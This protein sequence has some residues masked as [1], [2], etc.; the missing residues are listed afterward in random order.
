MIIKWFGIFSNML[1]VLYNKT[2]WQFLY[3]L[4]VYKGTNTS[5]AQMQTFIIMTKASSNDV[6]KFSTTQLWM[7][8][9]Q[10]RNAMKEL[11]VWKTVG[12]IEF[13][14]LHIFRNC[15]TSTVFRWEKQ[16][17]NV[18]N[19]SAT[20]IL[21][22]SVLQNINFLIFINYRYYN[23]CLFWKTE[24]CG[25]QCLEHVFFFIMLQL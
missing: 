22:T 2:P 10:W 7:K 24:H 21:N 11:F 8:K 18:S 3:L 6:I 5:S 9:C 15:W 20:L 16:R 4:L 12:Y 1:S 23:T 13:F 19:I 17:G 14:I 25:K